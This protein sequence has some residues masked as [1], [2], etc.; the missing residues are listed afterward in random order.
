MA[1]HRDRG[2]SWEWYFK[3]GLRE[4]GWGQVAW[5]SADP[6]SAQ[7]HPPLDLSLAPGRLAA[8]IPRAVTALERHTYA[9]NLWVPPSQF[10]LRVSDSF[11][12]GFLVAVCFFRG[13]AGLLGALWFFERPNNKV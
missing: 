5:S 11:Y 10:R 2:P 9:R 7:Q 3:E 6:L 8:E 12:T 4:P 13:F 1:S